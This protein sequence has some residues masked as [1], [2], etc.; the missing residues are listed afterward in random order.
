VNTPATILMFIAVLAALACARK[1][2]VTELI[3]GNFHVLLLF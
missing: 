1:P 3:F 2:L